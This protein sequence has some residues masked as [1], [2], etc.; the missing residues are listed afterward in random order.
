[1]PDGSGALVRFNNGKSNTA[2]YSQPIYGSDRLTSPELCDDTPQKAHLPVLGL[3]KEQQGLLM[4][5]TD[6]DVFASA[7]A[8]VSGMKKIYNAAY[9]SFSTWPSEKLS[10]E[11]NQE[12]STNMRTNR[13]RS[14][15]TRLGTIPWE[16]TPVTL[17]WRPGT[18][19][20]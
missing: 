10:I 14:G 6:G 20:I 15:N 5:T 13:M 1:M 19:S 9:F 7:N 3:Y 8:Y 16:R 17:R 4:V 18:A 2:E 12:R 11:T